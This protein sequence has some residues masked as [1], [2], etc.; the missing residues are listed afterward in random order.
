MGLESRGGQINYYYR[1]RRIGNRVT[2]EYVG[3]GELAAL[4][5][6]LDAEDREEAAGVK[7]H[8][9]TERAEMEADESRVVAHLQAVER[10]VSQALESAGYHRPSRKLM[11]LKKR[12]RRQSS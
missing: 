5:W 8:W 4:A 11:W 1:K 7:A 10:A 3:C 2:S 9:Q 6:L 12:G